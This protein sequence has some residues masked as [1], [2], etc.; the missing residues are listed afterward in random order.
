VEPSPTASPTEVAQ[1]EGVSGEVSPLCLVGVGL[2]V[3][4]L[5]VLGVWRWRG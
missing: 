4:G 2:V 5:I 3:A 1:L